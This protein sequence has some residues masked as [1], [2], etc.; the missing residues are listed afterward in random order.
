M[1]RCDQEQQ[2]H[3][4]HDGELDAPAAA[5]VESHL[6]SCPACSAELRLLRSLGASLR[7]LAEATPIPIGLGRSVH[8]R[9]ER[10]ADAGTLRLAGWLT[11]A[12]A[13]VVL[14]CVVKLESFGTDSTGPM[15][16]GSPTNSSVI[17]TSATP[18]AET[19]AA[20][21]MHELGPAADEDQQI[22]LWMVADLSRRPSADQGLRSPG[23]GGGRE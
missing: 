4:Y 8:R 5:A 1:T 13:A 9:V 10:F 19:A 6:R 12:A 3:R 14:A 11:A 15:W 17:S 20:L 23:A 16:F 22:A 18:A 2:V 7:T 21:S